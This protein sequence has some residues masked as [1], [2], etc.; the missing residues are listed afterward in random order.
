VAGVRI[1]GGGERT[2]M[3]GVLALAA[4]GCLLGLFAP[5]PEGQHRDA[6]Q[7][8][9]LLRLISA[10]ALVVVILLGPGIIWRSLSSRHGDA[11]LAFLPLPGLTLLIGTGGLAWALSGQVEPLTT[12]SAVI[13]PVLGLMLG[14]LLSSG[15]GEL[16]RPAERRC[17]IVAGGALGLALARAVWAPGPEG[18]LYGETISRTLEVGNRSDSR[19]P[20]IIP[21]LVAHDEGPYGPMAATFFAPYNFSS[22]GPLSGL[23]STPIVFLTGGSPP[24][25]FAEQPWA[26]FDAQGFMAFRV[27]LMTLAATAFI[28]LWD[29]TRRLMGNGAAHFAL[30]LAAA[31][32]F[33]IHEVWFTWPKLL[34]ASF[35]LLAGICVIR[36][37]FLSAGA[38]LGVGYLM[39]PVALISLPA[40]ILVALWP[41]TDA[42]W[43]R[44]RVAGLL[45]FLGGVAVFL[46]GWRVLNGSHYDQ[47]GFIEYVKQT[48]VDANADLIDW[49][50]FRLE[51]LANTLIPLLL[52]FSSSES[53][54]IN[55]VGGISPSTIHFFFQYWNTVPFGMAIVFFPLLLLALWRAAR[56][57]PWAVWATVFIPFIAFTVYWGASETGM[58]REGLQ[59]WALTLLV[60]VGCQQAAAGYSWLRS[61]PIRLLLSLRPVEVLAMAIGPALATEEILVSEAF[62]VTDTVALLTMAG[63]SV[64]LGALVWR[65]TPES[66]RAAGETRAPLSP[67]STRPAAPPPREPGSRHD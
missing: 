5:P 22:R 18:E 8:L 11:G 31:T 67:V 45:S 3:L 24:S 62:V 66:V 43:R 33:L 25:T 10:V 26:P 19:I 48:G 29:L 44:P 4:L 37:R 52:P 30:L 34:A 60:V 36:G 42:S 49:V 58:M 41:L 20:F 38:L 46:V 65:S 39:H 28:S 12:C 32:P 21:Q 51:S 50:T 61:G 9:D 40:L 13:W 59:A 17:V 35:V 27:A 1:T 54:W 23:G 14:C 16:L 6:E 56:R 57:W 2:V 63:L 64:W 7:M 47:T 15:P 55:V 53:G